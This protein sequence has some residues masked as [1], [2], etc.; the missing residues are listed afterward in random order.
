MCPM[1][2]VVVLGM[3]RF[4]SAVAFELTRLGHEVLAID[5][6]ERA[7][8]EVTSG[9]THAVEADIT[10][11]E[12]MRALGVGQFDAAIVAVATNIEASIF[13]T[14]TLKTLGVP[15]IVAKAGS[16]VHGSILRQVGAHR[17]VYPEHETGVRVAHSFAAPGVRDYLDVA[18]GYG[19]ARVPVPDEW[20]GRSVADL[21][22]PAAYHVTPMALH[23]SE[24]VTLN[25][26]R[27]EVLRSGDELIVA[28]LDED[29]ARL[30]AEGKVPG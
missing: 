25:P 21:D 13:S 11:Q 14:V 20:I 26:H 16:E 3:G 8:R 30:P 17:V 24:S 1:K 6:N 5:H 28:G 15:R 22:L 7:V 10:D 2:Q 27:S 9:V 19:F 12:A 23:R 18:P 29:L 4:G